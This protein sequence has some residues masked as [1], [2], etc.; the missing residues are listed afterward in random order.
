MK[1]HNHFLI[2]LLIA[3]LLTGCGDILNSKMDDLIKDDENFQTAMRIMVENL[4]GSGIRCYIDGPAATAQLDSPTSIATNED[5]NIVF[6]D[7]G[8][9]IVR[10][11][12]PRQ[13]SVITYS[14]SEQV[15]SVSGCDNDEPG[16]TFAAN[17]ASGN[18][19]L[20]LNQPTGIAVDEY[21]HVII[22]DR[23]NHM[24]RKLTPSGKLLTLAGTGDPGYADGP[25]LEAQFRFPT[26]VSVDK[27]GNILVADQANHRIRIISPSGE[28]STLAGNG[29]P[30]HADGPGLEAQFT[31]PTDAVM[32]ED[33]NV[34]VADRD[35]HRIRLITPS[36]NVTTLAGSGEAGFADGPGISAQFNLPTGVAVDHDG[37]VIV[38]DHNNNR[39][40]SVAPSGEVITMA[41]SG[42][43]GFADGSGSA[44]RFNRPTDIAL[45]SEGNIIVADFGNHRLRQVSMVEVNLD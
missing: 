44:A 20:K 34:F 37:N 19:L 21:N 2:V 31:G 41:G 43:A 15:L 30:G 9:N 27:H 13:K 5:G 22:A 40:R 33:G 29:D 14:I 45:D 36:G 28:V 35:N 39:I 1:T 4:A 24:I 25:G 8:N 18:S 11:Y 7:T 6:T 42:V 17:S 16:F 38:A 12:N 26:N 32:D 3:T 10:I 23:G